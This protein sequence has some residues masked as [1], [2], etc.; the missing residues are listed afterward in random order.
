[1]KYLNMLVVAGLNIIIGSFNSFNSI[2]ISEHY[3]NNN[4]DRNLMGVE[5]SDSSYN[6]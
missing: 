1:M 3:H 6:P 2:H 5:V 4:Y